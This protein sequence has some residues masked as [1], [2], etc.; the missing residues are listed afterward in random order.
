MRGN[1]NPPRANYL[2]ILRICTAWC[3]FHML[4]YVHAILHVAGKAKISVKREPGTALSDGTG[5]SVTDEGAGSAATGAPAP[6]LLPPLDDNLTA[7]TVAATADADDGGHGAAVV[8]KQEGKA[9]C[10][11]CV[12]SLW[13]SLPYLTINATCFP[14]IVTCSAGLT[15][16][17]NS[18]KK[19]A[20]TVPVV[21]NKKV[22]PKRET[23]TGST[24]T[25]G[26]RGRSHDGRGRG[27]GRSGRTVYTQSEVRGHII[28]IYLYIIKLATESLRI[29]ID[30]IY[31]S[32]GD[33]L[34]WLRPR[35]HT[36][37]DGRTAVFGDWWC[38]K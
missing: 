2:V 8:I 29:P 36:E 16:G 11:L 34:S 21:R 6:S 1:N 31:L 19:F 27:R 15:R 5:S 10:D 13:F 7:T 37:K 18:K 12:P 23:E 4:L 22:A 30:S 35:N 24:P 28:Y 25:R 9:R 26:G 14:L 38:C 17:G 32:S 20:P 33:L 3:H